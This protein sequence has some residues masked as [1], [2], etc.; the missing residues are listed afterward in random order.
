MSVGN[1][2]IS[3]KCTSCDNNFAIS[4]FSPQKNGLYGVC[5]TCKKCNA[6]RVS[7]WRSKNKEKVKKYKSSRKYKNY[8]NDYN[9]TKRQKDDL[10]RFKYNLV[11]CISNSFSRKNIK[12]GSR[13]F[14]ILG[15]DYEYLISW[16]SYVNNKE[17][18]NDSHID[19]VV[20]I[21]LAENEEELMVLNHF[22]NLQIMD[23]EENIKKSNKYIVGKNLERVLDC[24]PKFEVIERIVQRSDIEII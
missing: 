22:S 4:E 21:S 24:N 19:H 16:F 1:G 15:C 6:K 11:R 13:T 23:S 10:H 7:E 14:D 18:C 20:P 17:Y 3:K 2:I 12:K 9:K 8:V 5:S